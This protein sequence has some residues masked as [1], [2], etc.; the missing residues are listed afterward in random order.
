MVLN[1]NEYTMV[2]SGFNYQKP[3]LFLPN[4]TLLSSFLPPKPDGP[5]PHFFIF[6][7]FSFPSTRTLT[8]RPADSGDGDGATARWRGLSFTSLYSHSPS[9]NRAPSLSHKLFCFRLRFPF[10]FRR[11]G[12]RTTARNGETCVMLSFKLVS[13]FQLHSHFLLSC[14]FHFLC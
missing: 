3:P 1:Q 11:F 9:P 12:H 6:F 4:Q 5:P 8:L 2:S 10:V 13:C 14:S 7:V